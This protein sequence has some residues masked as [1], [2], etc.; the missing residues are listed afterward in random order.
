MLKKEMAAIHKKL[1]RIVGLLSKQVEGN[2]H[3]LWFEDEDASD[4]E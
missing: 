4:D 1:D 2:D 3:E